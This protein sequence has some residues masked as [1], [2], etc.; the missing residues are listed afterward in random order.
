MAIAVGLAIAASA[1]V[2]ARWLMELRRPKWLVEKIGRG[3]ARGV[4]TAIGLVC[5]ALG[6]VVISGWRPPW[7]Q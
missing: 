1:I 6:L 4:L 5:I 7:A 3:G 2:D